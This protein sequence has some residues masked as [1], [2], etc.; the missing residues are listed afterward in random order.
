MKG[1]ATLLVRSQAEIERGCY[2]LSVIFF[3]GRL[4]NVDGN[5]TEP[6][7]M[8]TFIGACI[9]SVPDPRFNGK[10]IFKV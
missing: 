9:V 1:E 3:T 7:K 4:C 5:W 2:F 10:F 6:K 8:K